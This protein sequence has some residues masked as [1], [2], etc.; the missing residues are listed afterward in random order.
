[1]K[2]VTTSLYEEQL[3]EILSFLAQKN[4]E[5]TKKF[6]IYLDTILI[7]IPTKDKKYK[8][9]IYFENENIKDVE[10]QGCTVIFYVDKKNDTYI[11]LG[12]TIKNW[13]IFAY[14][15]Y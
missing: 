14:Y 6:K 11:I 10:Y 3:K 8:K 15:K 4:Y 9:S 1:M 12:I 5:E 13:I 7:N 2:I